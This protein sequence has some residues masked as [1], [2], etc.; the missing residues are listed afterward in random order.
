MLYIHFIRIYIS[1]ILYASRFE[2][3]RYDHTH[4]QAYLGSRWYIDVI[5]SFHTYIYFWH[6]YMHHGLRKAIMT[7]HASWFKKSHYAHTH[8]HAYLSSCWYICLKHTFLEICSWRFN[9]LIYHA[10]V[11]FL[12]LAYMYWYCTGCFFNWYPP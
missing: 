10:F 2:K 9:K 1:D 12:K 5:Y 11:D 4:K 3:G 8:K 7:I 6:F